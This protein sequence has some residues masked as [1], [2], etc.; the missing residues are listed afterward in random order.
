MPTNRVSKTQ[1]K[2]RQSMKTPPQHLPTSTE[3]TSV[4]PTTKVGALSTGAPQE[5]ARR[6]VRPFLPDGRQGF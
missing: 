5:P 4:P 6:Y 3:A 1:Q 2:G